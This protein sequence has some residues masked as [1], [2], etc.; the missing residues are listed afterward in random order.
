MRVKR[1]AFRTCILAGIILLLA[2][3]AW[4]VFKPGG[5]NELVAWKMAA[6]ARGEMFDLAKLTPKF[7]VECL[8]HEASFSNAAHRLVTSPLAP[9]V[10]DVMGRTNYQS[11]ANLA[12]RRP[13]PI[14]KTKFPFSWEEVAVQM[15]TNAPVFVELRELLEHIPPG[16]ARDATL[17]VRMSLGPLISKRRAAQM[18]TAG[19]VSDLHQGALAEALDKIHTLLLL[20][21]WH[22]GEFTLVDTMIRVAIV[23]LTVSTTW[24]ALQA[25]GWDEAKLERL[26]TGLEGAAIWPKM[27]R[28]V[29]LE[30]AF[31]LSAYE[32]ARTNA[33]GVAP[34]LAGPAPGSNRFADFFNES[35]YA[36]AW[37]TAWS[38]QD[39]LL[40]L[41]SM[42]GIG[43]A[44]SQAAHTRSFQA[45]KKGMEKGARDA[46]ARQGLLDRWRFPLADSLLPNWS[47]AGL[48]MLRG[49]TMR[50]MACA[51][52]AIERHRMRRGVLPENLQALTPEFLREPP[53]DF[54]NGGPLRYHRG[55]GGRF[56]LWS[57]GEDGRD[58]EGK[59][60]SDDLVWPEIVPSEMPH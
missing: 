52:V 16:S 13:F 11:P 40:Y 43:D 28:T 24:E 57:V 14:E 12:W 3:S 55:E 46:K 5:G 9:G 23:G 32:M 47:K 20:S 49:E 58:G 34:V 25:P 15:A 50:E 56:T 17:G 19:A 59:P 10:T 8:A 33:G 41:K 31:G 51:A 26:Q 48:V 44:W 21:R 6:V 36:P 38:Q 1:P 7:S 39:E 60:G 27:E 54:M 53:H 18:L 35:V 22:E 4:V 37:Q 30:R 2:L 42:Q 45:F 29:V